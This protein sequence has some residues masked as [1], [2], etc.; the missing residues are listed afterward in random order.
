MPTQS[1]GM[2]LP[3]RRS[4]H[5]A[6]GA[7]RAALTGPG[8]QTFR[9]RAHRRPRPVA[10]LTSWRASSPIATGSSGQQFVVENRPGGA[11]ISRPKLNGANPR[12]LRPFKSHRPTGQRYLPHD[13]LNFKLIRDIRRCRAS[14]HAPNSWSQPSF[15][16]KTVPDSLHTQG[17]RQDYG[18][19]W[20]G[21]RPSG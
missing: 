16:A 3:H 10:P 17:P 5:P 20:I 4:P 18:I 12:W 21:S 7:P 14:P 15:P 13:K 11:P 19:G 6:V 8:A 9:R 2:K 1:L